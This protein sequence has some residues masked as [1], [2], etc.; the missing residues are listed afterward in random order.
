MVKNTNAEVSNL[1]FTTKE[2]ACGEEQ[3][4]AGIIRP[5]TFRLKI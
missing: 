3:Y 4:F 5:E 2:T 1:S